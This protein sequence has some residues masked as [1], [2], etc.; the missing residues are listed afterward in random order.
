[1]EN[2]GGVTIGQMTYGF[3]SAGVDSFLET[4]KTDLLV[5]ATTA[6]DNIT[7]V[8]SAIN[9]GWTGRA[10]TNYI[11]NFEAARTK[12][13]S[14]LRSEYDDIYTRFTELAS[15]YQEQDQNLITLEN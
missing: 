6:I 14:D 7:T 4:I 8:E 3:S 12:I 1:M 5:T 9:A 13:K 10:R 15:A 11:D 2:D